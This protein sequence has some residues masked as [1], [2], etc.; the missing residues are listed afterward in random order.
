MSFKSIRSVGT[1]LSL[2]VIPFA[3]QAADMPIYKAR[4]AQ[5]AVIN[6][7]TGF[8]L[9][10]HAGYALSSP[11][12]QYDQADAAG[13]TD[14]GALKLNGLVYGGQVGYNVQ[15]SNFVLGVEGDGSF[16]TVKKTIHSPEPAPRG[17]DPVTGE[18]KDLASFRA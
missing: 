12:G 2:L 14:L 9:G 18:R 6:N 1:A 4:A 5:A 7:W 17:P 10:G 11:S 3:A 16:G 13:P 8:Y 15:F